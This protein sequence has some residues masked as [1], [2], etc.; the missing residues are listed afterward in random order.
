MKKV[1]LA[2]VLLLIFGAGILFLL[3]GKD[4]YE[5][6]KYS[7]TLTNGIVAG[8][9]IEFTLPDQFDKSQT[10]DDSTKILIF[11]FSKETGHIVKEYLGAQAADYLASR[12][13]LFIADISPMPV[14]IR[15]TFALPD[16]KSQKYSVN[17]I[18]DKSI[19]ESFKKGVQSDKI[20]IV[21]L[22][23]KE[24]QKVEYA[25]TAQELQSA[26]R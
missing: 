14:V 12:H 20:T 1:L 18:Y 2:I 7:A 13:A 4:G 23:N 3:K 26:L 6:D 17:L 24:I 5:A 22:N 15:N 25:S 16:L 10:L 9:S 19:A 21:T 8:S 11:A